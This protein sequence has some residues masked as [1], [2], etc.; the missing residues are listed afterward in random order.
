MCVS[1]CGEGL[2]YGRLG[3]NYCSMVKHKALFL[4][5]ETL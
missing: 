1:V 4:S 5:G 3:E 2:S